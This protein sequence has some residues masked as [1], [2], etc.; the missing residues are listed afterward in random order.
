M[1]FCTRCMSPEPLN[2]TAYGNPLCDE[3]WDEYLDSNQG[4]VE[5]FLNIVRGQ[6]D[7]RS[8]DADFLFTVIR[9]WNAYKNL[10]DLS[11][12]EIAEYEEIAFHIGLL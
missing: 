3:C 5:Y 7:V 8:F 11:E 6:E 1:E 12:A 4:K 10:L 2:Q 9:S